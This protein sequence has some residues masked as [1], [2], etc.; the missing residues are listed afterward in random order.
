[1][2]KNIFVLFPCL[3]HIFN[4]NTCNIHY[5]KI[6]ILFVFDLLFKLNLFLIKSCDILCTDGLAVMSV[7]LGSEFMK[8]AI[9]RPGVPMEIALN[10]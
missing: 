2:K 7:D 6:N 9:V 3:H 1:M 4:R 10:K 8:V 5:F